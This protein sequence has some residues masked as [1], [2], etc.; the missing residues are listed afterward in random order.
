[1]TGIP[2]YQ[3]ARELTERLD[4]GIRNSTPEGLVADVARSYAELAHVAVWAL[5]TLDDMPETAR[6]QWA[7]M[8]KVELNED[9]EVAPGGTRTEA[10]I[11]LDVLDNT[12]VEQAI[13]DVFPPTTAGEILASDAI[14]AL[15]YRVREACT[16]H[17]CRPAT[18]FTAL[19]DASCLTI[20]GNAVQDPPAYLA[21]K[22]RDL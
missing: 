9:N 17:S 13:R 14:G 16:Q 19:L 12:A 3:R 10:D 20:A 15:C 2:E 21:A 8:L 1:M 5:A 4:N 11:A 7:A 18:V 22:V 6:E